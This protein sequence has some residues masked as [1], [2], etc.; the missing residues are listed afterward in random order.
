MPAESFKSSVSLS[1]IYMSPG[2]SRRGKSRPATPGC[3]KLAEKLGNVS[4]ACRRLGDTRSQFYEYKRRYRSRGN[5]PSGRIWQ[6]SLGYVSN[7]RLSD[8]TLRM[9]ATS[10]VPLWHPGPECPAACSELFYGWS[11]N[12]QINNCFLPNCSDNQP[13][14]LKTHTVA[15]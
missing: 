9:A 3:P 2:Q 12:H 13:K 15:I 7:T 14:C 5:L 8:P 10:A 11:S 6:R 1:F 4:E